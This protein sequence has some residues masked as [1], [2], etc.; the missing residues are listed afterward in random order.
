[1]E[2]RKHILLVH[3]DYGI[4]TGEEH[5]VEAI[6]NLM[7]S[8]G[9]SISWFRRSSV[10]IGDSISKKT[11]A[12]FAG[13][14]SRESRKRMA[15]ILDSEP[16]DLVQVQNLYPFISPS[17]LPVC[18]ERRIPVVMRCPNYRL[19]CPTGLHLYHGKVCERCL[20]GREWHCVM[21]NCMEDIPKSI[22]Y[23]ARNA[24][25]RITGMIM[26]NVTLFMVLSEFQK[27]RFIDGGIPAERVV[28]LPNMAPAVVGPAGD[29][30]G[31]TVAF[32]GRVSEEKG[33]RE[34]LGAARRL[35]G[36]RFSV[37]GSNE[38]IPQASLH[39][40][41]NL[42]FEGFLVGKALDDFYVKSRMLVLPSIWFEGFPNVIAT[43]MLHRKP[44]IA[45]RIGAIPEIV[46]DGVTGLLF[47]PG[48]V[49][50]L[51]EKIEYLWK[52]PDLCRKMGQAGWQK[53]RTEYSE[54]VFCRRLEKIYDKALNFD[55]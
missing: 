42:R 53:A 54:E 3:N 38:R 40:P 30:V 25:A 24:V 34:F 6:A 37:A 1:M 28:V 31:E 4:F 55:R 36:L 9:H 48:D 29:V 8:R 50:E 15:Q 11:Q 35:S 49:R 16:I 46:D 39:A 47:T 52:R 12:L 32:V 44:V 20:G 27:K 41:A 2:N 7:E 18:K 43:A 45:S 22:G 33:I 19:F 13:I 17:V 5:A 51:V 10:E 14:Y 26:D 23:A 21:Q